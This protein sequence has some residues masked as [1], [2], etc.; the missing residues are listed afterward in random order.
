MFRMEGGIPPLVELF[1]FDDATLQSAA[2]GA[3]GSLAFENDENKNQVDDLAWLLGLYCTL[4]C[5][6]C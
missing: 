3:L 5:C 6:S 2:A 4:L 1:Q